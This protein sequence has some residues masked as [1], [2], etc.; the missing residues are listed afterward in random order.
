MSE[1]VIKR[2]RLHYA[3]FLALVIIAGCASRSGIAQYWPGCIGVY[4]G[5]T[6]WALMIFLG[7]GLIFPTAATGVIA[8]V[9]LVFAYGVE[10][11]QLYQADWIESLRNTLF[12]ALVLGSGFLWSDLICYT[13]GCAVGVA[14]ETFG[15]Y[16]GMFHRR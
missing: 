12:G 15:R 16:I 8:T 7:I 10:F 11:S 9:V 4:G 2:N 1:K 3:I 14:G 5:D 6:L 13:V